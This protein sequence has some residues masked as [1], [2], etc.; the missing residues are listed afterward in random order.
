MASSRRV[1]DHPSASC[2]LFMKDGT[3]E[4]MCANV[5]GTCRVGSGWMKGDRLV[6]CD[7]EVGGDSCKEMLDHVM[8]NLKTRLRVRPTSFV[9]LRPMSFIQFRPISFVRTPSDN[10]RVTRLRQFDSGFNGTFGP[11]SRSGKPAPND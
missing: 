10:S 2:L 8:D 3:N 1:C 7:E 9:Q 5:C 11:R 6:F 4:D